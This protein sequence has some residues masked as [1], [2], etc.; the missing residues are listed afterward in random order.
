MDRK[1][2]VMFSNQCACACLLQMMAEMDVCMGGRAAEELIFGIHNITSGASSDLERATQVAVNMVEKLG[3]S[4]RIGFVSHG[5]GGRKSRY[6]D[7]G[8]GSPSEETR[9]AIDQEVRKLAEESYTRAK[10]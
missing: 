5:G 1:Q 7:G 2:C 10:R 6:S 8:G 3:M 4:V 9:A